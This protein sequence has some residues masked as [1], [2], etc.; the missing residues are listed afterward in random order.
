MKPL[1]AT[2]N[3]MISL[4]ILLLRIMGGLIL[5]VAGASKVAG[6]FGGFGMDVTVQ[7]FKANMGLAAH[8]AYISSYAE[9]IGGGLLMIGAL[10][11][12]AAFL[13]FINM[14]VAVI[15]VGTKNFFMGGAAYPCLLMVISLVILITGPMAFSVDALLA[16]KRKITA[17]NISLSAAF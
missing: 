14:L 11:R 8:W 10:T 6:W 4:G 13:L 15:L 3:N 5:F 12:P 17:N 16:R 7:M 2:N 9:F 1:T